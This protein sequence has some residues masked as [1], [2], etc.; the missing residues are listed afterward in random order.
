MSVNSKMTAIANATRALDGSTA[1]LTL[2]GIASKL[3]TEKTNIGAAL[4][5]IAEKGVTVP[6][7]STSDALASLIA[8]IEA[9]GGAAIELPIGCAMECAV[10]IPVENKTNWATVRFENRFKW[11]TDRT[12]VTFAAFA[13]INPP[14]QTATMLFGFCAYDHNKKKTSRTQT[15][16]ESGTVA[17]HTSDCGFSTNA[18]SDTFRIPATS[19]FPLLAG[20]SYFCI[21]VGEVV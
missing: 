20:V 14:A 11:A 8:S 19:T 4:A 9:G 21:A 2:D 6:D 10:Y 1:A 15:I 18:Q 5:A 16:N 3:G 12:N 13:A 7:G 17:T